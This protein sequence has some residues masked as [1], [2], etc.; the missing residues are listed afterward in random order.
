M[1]NFK[2]SIIF[3]LFSSISLFA[4]DYKGAEIYSYDSVLYG[5]FEMRIKAASGS[6]QLSTFFLYRFNSEL[7][8]TLWEEIDIEIFGKDTNVFQSN[9]IIEKVEGSRLMSEAVHISPNHLMNE[10]NTYVLEWTP[11]SICWYLNGVLL[12]T[13]KVFAQSC[14]A[15]MSI[16]FNHWAADISSWVG[17]FDTKTLPQYQYVDYLS[18]STYTPGTGDNGSNFTHAWTDNFSSFNSNRWGKANWTFGENFCDFLPENVYIENDV[19]VL[20]LHSIYPIVE[21]SSDMD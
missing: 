12:R 17:E 16:R 5:R 4:K 6:G 15:P 21:S 1:R 11:D 2:Y 9:V 7:S 18:Y 13:E 3:F 20:K 10:Y 19:L 8:T 14:N